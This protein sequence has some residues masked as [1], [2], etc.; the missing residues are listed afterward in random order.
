MKMDKTQL[1]EN[2]KHRLLVSGHID[3]QKIAEEIARRWAKA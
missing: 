3:D 2:I 1:I